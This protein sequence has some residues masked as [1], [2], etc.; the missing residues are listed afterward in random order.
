MRLYFAKS[1]LSP[2]LTARFAVGTASV[3]SLYLLVLLLLPNTNLALATL[4]NS[5]GIGEKA[6]FLFLLAIGSLQSNPPGETLLILLTALLVGMNLTLFLRGVKRTKTQTHVLFGGE[7]L[8][9]AAATGCS[10]CGTSLLSVLAVGAG[11]SIAPL[12]IILIQF[13]AIGLLLY[14]LFSTLA[15]TG[16]CRIS[17][18]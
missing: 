1:E 4:Q 15:R 16:A 10:S 8:L 3:A 5:L 9:G 18:S 14:S 11:I 12:Q 7:T 6:Q 13:A 2:L 17:R